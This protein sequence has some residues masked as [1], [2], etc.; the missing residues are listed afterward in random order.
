MSYAASAHAQDLSIGLSEAESRAVG[1]EAEVTESEAQ[2]DSAEANYVTSARQATPALRSARSA[3]LRVRR[4]EADIAN[5]QQTATARIARIEADHE[6]EVKRHDDQ[7]QSGIGFGLAALIA[8]AIALG[9]GWFRATAAVA[10]LSEIQ[11]GQA[12]ALCVFG[13]LTLVITGAVMAG[14]SGLVAIIGATLAF[15]G[16]VIPTTLL[17]ARH[18]ARIQRGRTKPVLKRERM[19]GWVTKSLAAVF[20]VL[21]L[22]GFSSTIFSTDPTSAAISTQ[23]RHQASGEQGRAMTQRLAATEGE[24]AKLERAASKLDARRK[25]AREALRRV[26]NQIS[27]AERQLAQAEASAH[28]FTRRLAAV[29]ARE[30]REAEVAERNAERQAEEEAELT[31]EAEQCDP[32]YSGCLDPNSPDYD[33]EG[34]SGDG[35]DYTGTVTVTG[36]DHYGLDDDGDGI[37]CDP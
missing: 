32:N 15:L 36:Y 16:F 18:S 14:G 5:R 17:L 30:T 29:S 21:V 24:A 34:G 7:V 11:P 22:V 9:W 26:R 33:C 37:G 20:G 4:L 2:L 6:D 10:W 3:R 8:G 25:T 23:L 1:A 31:A 28:H 35:P 19:P 12:M 13:G 27:S